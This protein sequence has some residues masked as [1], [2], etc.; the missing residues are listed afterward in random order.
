MA[1]T[2]VKNLTPEE[3]AIRA[4]KVKALK[5][6]RKEKG[7]HLSPDDGRLKKNRPKRR[8]KYQSKKKL[9][10][11][12][13]HIKTRYATKKRINNEL[14]YLRKRVCITDKAEILSRGIELNGHYFYTPKIIAE[15]LG[16]RMRN[17]IDWWIKKGVLPEGQF[18]LKESGTS[19]RVF[20]L[21]H[22]EEI[23]WMINA[24]FAP[25]FEV[26]PRF[27]K[28]NL[29]AIQALEMLQ[30]EFKIIYKRRI[31]EGIEKYNPESLTFKEIKK[32]KV[33]S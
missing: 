10:R 11:N 8:K 4:A 1:I 29:F 9:L 32:E 2:R 20:K 23:Y 21:Y 5:Q 7:L 6:I 18:H 27:T 28:N 30:R 16:Y 26:N 13:R 19:K 24:I 14:W 33:I 17:A 31:K 25:I 22:F 12:S 3:K 15:L